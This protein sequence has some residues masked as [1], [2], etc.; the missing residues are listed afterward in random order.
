MKLEI[1]FINGDERKHEVTGDDFPLAVGKL[2]LKPL[3][4]IQDEVYATSMIVKVVL[5]S[6]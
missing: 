5:V 4:I 3:V 2:I 6:M 1:E